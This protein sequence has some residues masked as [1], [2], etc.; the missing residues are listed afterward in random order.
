MNDRELELATLDFFNTVAPLQSTSS[1]EAPQGASEPQMPQQPVDYYQSGYNERLE[2]SKRSYATGTSPKLLVD[3][4]AVLSQLT[5]E[6]RMAKD[7]SD[8]LKSRGDI[9]RARIAREQYMNEKFLPAVEAIIAYNSVDELLNSQ[10]II[11]ELDKLVLIDGA[12]K[13]YTT[14]YIKTAHQNDRGDFSGT[15][16]AEVRDGVRQ[17]RMLASKDYIRS[18]VGIAKRLKG[19]IDQGKNIASQEDYDL[20]QRV[21]LRAEG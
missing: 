13:G 19:N 1:Q 12:G 21:V 11:N 8:T 7:T 18:A 15:S 3:A 16:D 10:Q 4:K 14:A 9:N 20:I 2:A 5:R 6:Y 17:M